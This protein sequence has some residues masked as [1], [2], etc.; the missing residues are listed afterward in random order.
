MV[1]CIHKSGRQ[2]H[3]TEPTTRY[4]DDTEWTATTR[5]KPLR[6]CVRGARGAAACRP[7]S[8]AVRPARLHVQ[9][10]YSSTGTRHTRQTSNHY[11]SEH[12]WLLFVQQTSGTD[13]KSTMTV[14]CVL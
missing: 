2:R 11:I 13:I 3:W 6:V 1:H 8:G 4:S 14:H 12:V 10:V 7:T 9:S 5:D